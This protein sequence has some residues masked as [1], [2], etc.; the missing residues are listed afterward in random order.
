MSETW[1]AVIIGGSAAGLSAAL[2]LGRARRRVLVVDAGAPRNRFAEHMH[3]VLGWEGESPADLLRRARADVANYDVTIQ[4]G[5]ATSVDADDETVTVRLNDGATVTGRTLIA[6]SG[7]TDEMPDIP[8]VAQRWGTTVLHCPYCHGWEVREQRLGVLGLSP[9]S[10]HQ[11]QLIRQWTDDLTLFTAGAGEVAPELRARLESRG[12]KL[13]D[14]PVAEVLGDGAALSGVRLADGSVIEL[15]ALFAG[16][17]P[18]PNDGFLTDL[19]LD[20]VDNPMGNFLAVDDFGKTSHPLVWAV[21]NVVNPA[22]TVPMAI[23]AAAMTGGMV[24]MALVTREF[25]AATV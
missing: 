14:T 9:M 18:R 19:A 6:A 21:G 25:D 23:G 1:D 7:L 12:V 13:I 11:A 3:G 4:E 16:L 8:G 10:L 5:R 22:A 15:D 20:R 24:N 17:P 2:L